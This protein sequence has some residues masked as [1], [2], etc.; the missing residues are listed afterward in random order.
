MGKFLLFAVLLGTG[1]KTLMTPYIGVIAYYLLAILGPQY[2]WWW[3]FEGLRSSFIVALSTISSFLLAAAQQRFNYNFFFSKINLWVL[4]LWA[5]L[6]FS[7]LLGPYVSI[8]GDK[9]IEQIKYM[10]KIVFFYFLATIIIDDLKKLKMLSYVMII[11]SL[12]MIYWANSQYFTSNYSAFNHGRLM[13]PYS[14]DGGAIYKDENGFAMFFVTGTPFLFYWGQYLAKNIYQKYMAWLIVPLGWHA[15]FLTG[16][17]GGLVGIAATL[18]AGVFFSQKKK[19]AIALIPLLII[20]FQW[21]AGELL[22]NRSTTIVDYEGERSAETRIE[23]WTAA[24][25]MLKAYPITGVGISCFL[26]AMRD[27]STKQARQA[28]SVPFQFGA[29]AG[30]LALLSYV[31][32]VFQF[33]VNSLKINKHLSVLKEYLSVDE[34]KTLSYLNESSTASFF[35]LFICALFLPLNYYEIFYYL[36]I[37]SVFLKGYIDSICNQYRNN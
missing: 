16:S 4:V 37:F 23:A 24:I 12:Y 18:A 5:S 34:Y 27:F 10:N 22:K 25:Q 7:Y 14:L 6:V 29:E 31:L 33:F 2:I 30:I 15:V 9:P 26:R 35:G 17:R 3:N 36:L 19:M 28:H 21:Q 32:I 13:G 20:A 8:L 1:C 11:S